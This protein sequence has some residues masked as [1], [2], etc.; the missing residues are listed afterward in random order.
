VIPLRTDGPILTTS[1]AQKAN[2]S[3][4]SSSNGKNSFLIRSEPNLSCAVIWVDRMLASCSKEFELHGVSGLVEEYDWSLS[5]VTI[6]SDLF[7]LEIPLHLSTSSTG[8]IFTAANSLWQFQSLYGQIPTV[9][10]IGERSD[11]VWR[12]LRRLYVEKGEPRASPDQPVSHLFVLDRALDNASV[13]LTA[14]TYE[15]MLHDTFGISCG[16]V[17]FSGDVEERLKR[18]TGENGINEVENKTSKSKPVL[19]DNNDA[20][21]SAVRNSHMTAVFPFLS[22]KAKEI[23]NNYGKGTSF[24][25]VSDMKL[26]VSNELKSLKLQHRQLETHICACEVVLERTAMVNA[27]ERLEIEQAII[28]NTADLNTVFEYAEN[29]ML[30]DH[31]PWQIL[32]LICLASMMNN[33]LPGKLLNSFKESFI[34][35]YGIAFLSVLNTLSKKKLLMTRSILSS[36][37]SLPNVIGVQPHE[38]NSTLPFIVKRLSLVPT[39]TEFVNDFKN[40]QKMNYVFSGAYT[41][42][43]CQVVADV[44]MQGFNITDLKKT[45]NGKV[46]VE[47]NSFVPAERRPDSRMRK[48]IMVFFC[49]GVT[50]AEIAALRLLAQL[51]S[52]RIIIVATNIIHRETYIK[53]LGDVSQL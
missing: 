36:S 28:A 51:N 49:G 43:M 4:R 32:L 25:Q 37:T 47:E 3:V 42:V 19:L 5:L 27:S 39:A 21:F 34:S 31:S 18:T 10:G 52:F 12:V 6:E 29:C 2:L 26:F 20:V 53:C 45:F 24:D 38:G 46:F 30:M 13:F 15:S 17:T 35:S 50:Y 11:E 41:P 16:K 1:E 14:L 22:S 48:A 8:D 23:Q 7:S 44:M 40:P 33:G 9:Y